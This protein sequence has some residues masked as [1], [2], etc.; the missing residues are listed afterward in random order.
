MLT[1]AFSWEVMMRRLAIMMGV[2]T[3]LTTGMVFLQLNRVYAESKDLEIEMLKKKIEEIERRRDAELEMLKNRIM[4]LEKE[5]KKQAAPPQAEVEE[6]KTTV[7][8]LKTK[9]DE[10]RFSFERVAKFMEEHKLRAGLRLQTWYQFMED[11]KK[12]GTKN[13]NDFM[14]RRFYF[15]LS[16]EVTPKIGFFAHIAGDRIGQDGLD[17]P[18][19]GLGSGIAVRDAWVYYNV[20]ESFKIQMGRMYVPFTRNYSTTSTFAMLPLELPFN[21]GGV[22][23]GIFY[24]SKVGRDDGVVLWGNPFKGFVQYRLGISEGVESNTDN[25]DDNLRFSGRVSLNLLEPETTWFN[26][27]SYLGTKKVLALGAGFDYQ[28]DLVLSKKRGQDNIGWTVDLFF[29]HPVGKGAATF[30]AAFI[31]VKNMTQTLKYSRLISGDDA[32]MYYVQGGYLF[33]RH[34]GPGRIQPYFRYER[35]AVNHKPDTAFPCLGLNYLIKGHDA[36]LTLDWTLID[37]RKE[38]YNPQGEFSGKDQ[39][40]ITFQAA[41]GF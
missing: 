19:V 36:K 35:L 5:T 8:E 26:K 37:Q 18:S 28:D 13:L 31:D 1:D 4:V 32:Q 12:S 15:Y 39:N 24:A 34:I 21:Q 33:P 9:V 2:I 23:G 6:L 20:N 27:G 40:L 10:Q 7:S 22:R 17:S 11:G 14:L 25:P 3:F 16:G 41:M 29:D 38:V 30:E